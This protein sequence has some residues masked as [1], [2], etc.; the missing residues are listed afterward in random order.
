MEEEY[1]DSRLDKKEEKPVEKTE[2]I[3]FFKKLLK[4]VLYIILGFFV[5]NSVLYLVLSIPFVQS[6][7]TAFASQELTSLL[8][9]EVKVNQ[10]R[11]TLFNSATIKGL[12]VE[13]QTSD[14][15]V[16]AEYLH[17]RIKPIDFLLQGRLRV[18]QVQLDNFYINVTAADSISDYNFQFL[19]DEFSSSDS[20]AVDT[21]SS[22]LDVVVDDVKIAN[23]RF[24]HKIGGYFETPDEFNFNDIYVTDFN[25][26]VSIHSIDMEKLDVHVNSITAKE[27]SGLE[28]SEF[29]GHVLSEGSKLYVENLLFQ[30]PNSHLRPSSL[31]FDLETD[32]FEVVTDD[33]EISP[34]DLVPFLAN[35]KHLE[36]NLNLKTTIKGKLP[37]VDASE[38]QLW[39]GDDALLRGSAFISSYEDLGD[40]EFR[41]DVDELSATPRGLTAFARL[42]DESFA[43]PAI[44]DTLG[45]VYLDAHLKGKLNNFDLTS[46]ASM[47]TGALNLSASGSVDTTFTH[48]DVKANL[49]TKSFNLTPIV[50]KASGVG[51]LSM[52]I[53]V[54]A[55]QKGEGNLVAKLKGGVDSLQLMHGAVT[56]LPFAGYYDKHKM[57][58]GADAKLHF[59]RI[60][61]GFEMTQAVKPD[62]KFG[63][64]LSDFDVAHFYK[65][66]L[67]NKPMLDFKLRGQVNKLDIDNLDAD[68]SIK[69]FSF[70][71]ADFN[72]DPGLISLKAWK[73][74]AEVKHIALSSSIL[75]ANIDGNYKFSTLGEEFSEL[76]HNYLSNVFPVEKK[77]KKVEPENEFSFNFKLHN[78]EEL[79][80]IFDL[81]VDIVEPLEIDGI[82]NTKKRTIDVVGQL[83]HAHNSM[84]EIKGMRLNIANMDSAF[85]MKLTTDVISGKSGYDLALNVKGADNAIRSVFTVFTDSA[86]VKIKGK[87]DA[88]ARF[89][90]NSAKELVSFFEVIPSDIMIGKLAMNLLPAQ[91][92]NVGERT[93]ITDLGIGVNGKKYLNVNG[94]V[95]PNKEDSLHISFTKAQIADILQGVSVNDIY[96]EIDGS[97]LATNLLNAPELYTQDLKVKDITLYKDTIGTVNVE[98]SWNQER[99]G[100]KL[101]SSLVKKGKTIMDLEGIVD[102]AAETLDLHMDIERFSIAFLKPFVEGLL[103]DISGDISSHFT[104]KG[105]FDEPITEG[106][107]GFNNAK[108]GIDYTGVTY[109][110]S[111]TINIT[112]DRIGFR[113][114][115]LKDSQ[116]NVGVMNALVTHRNFKDMKYSLDMRAQNLLVLNNQTRTDSLFYGKL[117][118]SGTVNIK[119]SDTGIDLN[120]QL[121]NGKKSTLN[122]TVPQVASATDYKS[123]VYIN[124]PEDKLPKE[125]K[126]KPQKRHDEEVPFPIRIKMKLDV[127]PDLALAVIIDPQTGDKMNVKGNGTINFNYDML[128]EHMTVY[129]D[130]KVTDGGVRLNLQHISALDFKIK[131][132]SRLQFIGDPFKTKFDITAYRR[133]RT[134]LTTLDQ[135]FDQDSASPRVQVDCLLGISG[136]INKMSL[137]Y[138]IDLYDGTDDQKRKVRSLVNTNEIKIRQFAFLI[139]TGSFNSSTGSSGSNFTDNMWQGLASNALSMGLNAAFGSMLGDKWE[140]GAEVTDQDKSV[141]ATTTLFNDKLKLHANVGYRQ[142]TYGP[143]GDTFIGDFDVE[144]LLN[145]IWTLKAYSHTND[146]FYKPAPTTQGVGI[147][148]T[149][150]GPTM[151]AL[152]KSFRRGRGQW[153]RAEN[154]S[155]KRRNDSIQQ[156]QS[157]I[158]SKVNY[159][160]RKKETSLDAAKNDSIPVNKT[161]SV[162]VTKKQPAR[163]ED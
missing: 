160:D 9:T 26:S 13:D 78:S 75:S 145:S 33:T 103:T 5:L 159:E 131:D 3:G 20:T 53:D 100:M 71:D 34:K 94:I 163:K 119:G 76:M 151:K 135:S 8:K 111:D 57:G 83:P 149:R 140:L 4:V 44:L 50:G 17:A 130:Y 43:K 156:V 1:R 77:K 25:A 85:S 48:F 80:Y 113:N 97:I 107:L 96:A 52:H 144:Y 79:G 161:D 12:Y 136:D 21:T 99:G 108:I 32:E 84:V 74:T 133:V 87:M 90:M 72:Y 16:Y 137:T 139:S 123:V 39:Y 93:E 67:W 152:F 45:R 23:G 15:L 114:L 14:T 129:G 155:I 147:V 110:I 92:M 65:N 27:K 134:N 49:N 51:K 56:H 29:Q 64:N 68:I 62:I 41:V 120:M 19:I 153:R 146:Q 81:P 10:V 2:K 73:D 91:V 60:M 70:V 126:R 24:S 88:L 31:F 132:G 142:D 35:L 115:E 66:K 6:R 86:E 148:Y 89:E 121:R 162:A 143:S 42:G 38:I 28:I 138:D 112:P 37:L 30:L 59:G 106:F 47:K 122:V 158:P 101:E 82:V 109:F 11:F 69:D 36:H 157:G 124:V 22:M 63:L 127:N 98:T 117:F 154:D 18:N 54:E 58:F 125:D 128:T 104:I 7:L 150:E 40:A 102:P 141:N 105:K 95:S 118:A 116:G 61:A 46:K 55:N